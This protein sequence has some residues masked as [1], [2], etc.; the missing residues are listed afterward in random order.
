MNASSRPPTGPA[1]LPAAMTATAMTAEIGVM[2][3]ETGAMTAETGMMT[4]GTGT[5]TAGTG[6]TTAGTGVTTAETSMATIAYGHGDSQ[7]VKSSGDQIPAVFIK[8]Q[9]CTCF[10]RSGTACHSFS[11]WTYTSIISMMR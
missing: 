11:P 5:M 10:F 9:P 2:T 3:A 4:A 6:V 1:A 7:A 8:F